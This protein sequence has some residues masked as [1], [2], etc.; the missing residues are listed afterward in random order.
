MNRVAFDFLG[1]AVHRSHDNTAP[2]RAHATSTCIPDW[3]SRQRFLR[4]PHLRLYR[5]DDPPGC[6]G[7]GTK[8]DSGRGQLEKVPPGNL[9]IH[10]PFSPA[11]CITNELLVAGHTIRQASDMFWILFR[12]A[13]QAPAHVHPQDWAC[14]IHGANV[15]V[16]GFTVYARS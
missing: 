14:L 2:C 15:P 13:V 10:K 16:T 8:C 12:V 1:P 7:A 4:R 11:N 3:F 6:R 9:W 5:V